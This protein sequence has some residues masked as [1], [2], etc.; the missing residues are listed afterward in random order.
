MALSEIRNKLP[1]GV[2]GRTINSFIFYG[3]PDAIDYAR[4]YRKD[5]YRRAPKC[6][7]PKDSLRC[8]ASVRSVRQTMY[9][10]RLLLEKNCPQSFPPFVFLDDLHDLQETLMEEGRH[11][12]A[13]YLSE[14]E[15]YAE[16][17]WCGCAMSDLNEHLDIVSFILRGY[18]PY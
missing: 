5:L 1:Y 9:V 14:L 10:Y 11:S 4:E 3:H 7:V 13:R 2:L 6:I 16:G 15:D 17:H 8:I 12:L 18:E